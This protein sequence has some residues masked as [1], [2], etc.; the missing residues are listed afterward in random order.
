LGASA[1]G[2]AAGAGAGVVS[3]PGGVAG[4]GVVSVVAAGVVAAGFSPSLQ[5]AIT[6]GTPTNQSPQNSRR[7]VLLMVFPSFSSS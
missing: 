3:A 2:V 5:P 1:G 4:A 6:N 7:N